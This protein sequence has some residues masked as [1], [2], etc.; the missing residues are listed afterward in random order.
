MSTCASN[1]AIPAA[2]IH[3]LLAAEVVRPHDLE[4]GEPRE[5]HHSP[6]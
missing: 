4:R 5:L 2:D 3:N 6:G 1:L